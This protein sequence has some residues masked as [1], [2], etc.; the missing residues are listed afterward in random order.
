MSSGTRLSSLALRVAALGLVGAAATTI[1]VITFKPAQRPSNVAFARELG[2]P[3]AARPW[4]CTETAGSKSSASL[5]DRKLARLVAPVTTVH[6]ARPLRTTPPLH[7]SGYVFPVLGP[8]PPFSDT[9]GV[10]RADVSWH[11]GDD[12]FAARGRPVL[13]VAT[14]TVFSVGW[15]RIGGWRLWLLDRFGNDFYYAHLESYS[16]LAVDGRRVRAGQVLGY[17]GSSGDAE[18][19]PPHLFFEINPA[20]LLHLGYD[21]TVDPTSYLRHWQQLRAPRPAIPP[22]SRRTLTQGSCRRDSTP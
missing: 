17:V 20:T 1:S 10:P 5:L 15:N 12:L 21:G 3:V 18:H 13:A 9:F 8:Y 2:A 16:V 22:I 19:T 7:Q 14:G 11:H 4:R 6:L